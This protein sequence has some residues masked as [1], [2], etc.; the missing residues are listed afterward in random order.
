M[1]KADLKT[2]YILW[3]LVSASSP[4]CCSSSISYKMPEFRWF[5]Y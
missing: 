3:N 4:S 1:Y 5:G 2:K